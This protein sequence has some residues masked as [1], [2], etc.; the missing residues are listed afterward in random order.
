MSSEKQTVYKN[1][2]NWRKDEIRAE[3][4]KLQQRTQCFIDAE[5]G[6]EMCIQN[7]KKLNNNIRR[8]IQTSNG[9]KRLTP[10]AKPP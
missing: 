9:S 10:Y 4:S 5:N 3:I 6:L 1:P 7:V 8:L 2:C